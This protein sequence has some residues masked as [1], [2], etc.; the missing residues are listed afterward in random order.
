MRPDGILIREGST[1]ILVPRT[2]SVHGP[3]KIQGSVFFN[4][5][6]SFNRDVSVMFLRA[7]GRDLTVAD[8]MTATGSRAVRIANEVKGVQQCVVDACDGALEIPQH[9]TKHSLNVSVTAGIV[10]WEAARA[11]LP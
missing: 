1:D 8:A 5:Q 2:H 10:M 11:L 4:E 3:G 7:V 9:G 6:M